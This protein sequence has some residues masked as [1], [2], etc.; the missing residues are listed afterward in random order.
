MRCFSARKFKIHNCRYSSFEKNPGS[1]LCKIEIRT[2]SKGK[3]Q[4]FGGSGGFLNDW[5][6][7]KANEET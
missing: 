7:F 1:R 4:V 6:K 5:A 3:V 2:E